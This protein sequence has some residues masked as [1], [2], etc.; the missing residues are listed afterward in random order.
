MKT[1]TKCGETKNVSEF[2]KSIARKD[3]YV[4]HCKQCLKNRYKNL[5]DN[6][7]LQIEKAIKSSIIIDNKLLIQ[8]GQKLCSCCK[9][10]YTLNPLR[11]NQFR[12]LDCDKNIAR[13]WCSNNIEIKRKSNKEY[14]EINKEKLKEYRE[15]AKDYL[16]Q[17]ALNNNEKLKEYRK[18]Y[19]LKKKLEK[20]KEKL[21]K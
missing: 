1:C 5:K 19:Y 11:K 15:N 4:S 13:E 7:I 14:R 20:E 10:I 12:C 17:Y 21:S 2:N 18:Q 8:K 6:I 3:G 9:K 16:K